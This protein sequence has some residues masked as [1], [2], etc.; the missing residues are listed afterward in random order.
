M[1]GHKV[2]AKNVR[3]FSMNM[4]PIHFVLAMILGVKF[5]TKHCA[6]VTGDSFTIPYF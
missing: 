3:S 2:N 1:L 5:E 6:Y 4:V